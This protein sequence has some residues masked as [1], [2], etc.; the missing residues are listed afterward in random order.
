MP[1][2]SFW[3]SIGCPGN[4]C[5]IP[6]LFFDWST[7]AALWAVISYLGKG[8][9]SCPQTGLDLIGIILV[10]TE[11][12]EMPILTV[13]ALYVCCDATEMETSHQDKS[14]STSFY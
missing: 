12:T 1:V 13:T 7:R 8:G 10:C 3:S 2:A 5:N 4:H 14:S 6:K 9:S 11:L